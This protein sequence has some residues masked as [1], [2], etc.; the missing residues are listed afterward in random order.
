MNAMG[1]VLHKNRLPPFLGKWIFPQIPLI[2][3]VD[4]SPH[5]HSQYEMSF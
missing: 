1:I 4:G 3:S 2:V 5:A